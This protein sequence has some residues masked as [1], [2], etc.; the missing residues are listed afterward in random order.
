[1]ETLR[2]GKRAAQ[3]F[4]D[5]DLF[6]LITTS[7]QFFQFQETHIDAYRKYIVYFLEMGSQ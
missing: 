2:T 7:R 1:M 5:S 4:K 3:I 6:K